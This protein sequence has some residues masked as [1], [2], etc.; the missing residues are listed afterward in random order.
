MS[1]AAEEVG[2]ENF[3]AQDSKLDLANAC[4]EV[5]TEAK[6]N[7]EKEKTQINQFI[8]KVKNERLKLQELNKNDSKV[9][10]ELKQY[11]YSSEI[12]QLKRQPADGWET[13]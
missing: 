9:Q 3:F 10:S 8:D 12:E 11:V 6:A 13:I 1:T 4:S 5:N 7:I 2:A